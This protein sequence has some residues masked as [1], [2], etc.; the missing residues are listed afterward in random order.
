MAENALVPAALWE[1][2]AAR[3]NPTPMAVYELSQRA[4]GAYE[5][6]AGRVRCEHKELSAVVAVCGEGVWLALFAIAFPISWSS[7][8]GQP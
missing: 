5:V 1:S 3:V 2:S 6:A 7:D 4:V 8:W